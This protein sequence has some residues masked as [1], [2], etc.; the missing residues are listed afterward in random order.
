MSRVGPAS[1][2]PSAIP[3]PSDNLTQARAGSWGSA[4]SEGSEGPN[5][6]SNNDD[7]DEEPTSVVSRKR[8]KALFDACKLKGKRRKSA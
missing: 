2:V 3:M 6:D 1:S 5:N 7:N 8:K 4:S